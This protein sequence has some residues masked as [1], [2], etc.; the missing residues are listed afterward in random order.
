MDTT[1]D[2]DSSYSSGSD[3]PEESKKFETMTIIDGI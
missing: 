3:S 2:N 1:S